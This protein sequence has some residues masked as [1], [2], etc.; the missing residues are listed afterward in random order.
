MHT[1]TLSHTRT[2]NCVCVS[3][4]DYIGDRRSK[5]ICTRMWCVCVLYRSRS[6]FTYTTYIVYI[7]LSIYVCICVSGVDRRCQL[8]AGRTRRRCLWTAVAEV[9]DVAAVIVVVIAVVAAANVAV[10][11]VVVV[12]LQ[13]LL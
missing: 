8:F 9:A 4:V 5:Y 10:S 13:F 7:G 2:R 3:V 1:H 6:F 12:L 11:V